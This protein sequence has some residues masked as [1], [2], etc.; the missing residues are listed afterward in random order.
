MREVVR[1]SWLK[2]IIAGLFVLGINTFM[3]YS[4][5]R[6]GY[7]RGYKA[8]YDYGYEFGYW[9]RGRERKADDSDE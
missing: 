4:G 7:R 9:R 8:G 2:P 1:V 6:D 5:K 3:Y